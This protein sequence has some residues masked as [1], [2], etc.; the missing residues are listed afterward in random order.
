MRPLLS[1]RVCFGLTE[2][3]EA[4]MCR[5]KA[6]YVITVVYSPV[7]PCVVSSHSWIFFFFSSSLLFW[8]I[9]CSLT[10]FRAALHTRAKRAYNRPLLYHRRSYDDLYV[11]ST[12]GLPGCAPRRT[13]MPRRVA[14]VYCIFL[15]LLFLFS[16]SLSFLL[17]LNIP[18]RPSLSLFLSL[19]SWRRLVN[20]LRC[21]R[22]RVE[23][24]SYCEKATRWERREDRVNVKR[25]YIITWIDVT[26]SFYTREYRNKEM[27]EMYTL[28]YVEDNGGRLHQPMD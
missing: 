4:A 16:R 17:F 25:R 12:W 11:R 7:S 19:S 5:A 26:N 14:A 18:H 28:I 24:D 2:Q 8:T 1:K 6:A 20:L 10:L 15:F 3:R 27:Q 21:W 22:A 23:G 9:T 13:P